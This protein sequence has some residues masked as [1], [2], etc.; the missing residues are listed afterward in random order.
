MKKQILSAAILATLGMVAANSAVA[1]TLAAGDVLTI[2]P[3][4]LSTTTGYVTGGSYFGMDTNGN[5]I[6]NASE[7]DGLS[8]GVQGLVIGS[9]QNMGGYNTH[10][11]IPSTVSGDS[12]NINAPWA[13]F[14]NTGKNYTTSA[15]TGGTTHGLTMGGWT[16]SWNGIAAI[17]MGA[18]AWGTGYSN[19][20]ANF[21]WNG[22]IGGAYTLNYHGTVPLNDPSGFGG[23]KY[24]L[25]FTGTVTA[26]PAATAV[27]NLGPAPVPVPAAAWLFGSGMLGLVGVARR[28]KA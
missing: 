17:P 7:K 12:S 6:I 13:F 20:I 22:A 25:F 3:A 14:G 21:T 5:G 2:T 11:G 24:A 26:G 9:A 16:V 1:A 28:K 8:Q 4:T 18:G 23:V 27:P 19:G 15:I 10:S